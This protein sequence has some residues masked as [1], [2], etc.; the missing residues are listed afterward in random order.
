[1]VVGTHPNWLISLGTLVV[2]GDAAAKAAAVNNHI[3]NSES[4]PEF[5]DLMAKVEAG[6]DHKLTGAADT[7]PQH[8]LDVANAF[9]KYLRALDVSPIVR[10]KL[11]EKMYEQAMKVI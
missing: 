5:Q 1:M 4:S 10:G 6:V 7:V 11:V 9:E 8:S 3:I 2:I